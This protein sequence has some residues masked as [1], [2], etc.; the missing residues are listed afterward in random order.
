MTWKFQTLKST[1]ESLTFDD[2]DDLN[3]ENHLKLPTTFRGFVAPVRQRLQA[4]LGIPK[5][6]GKTIK[7]PESPG[8]GK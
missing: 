2:F 7:N 8:R 3:D 1:S 4:R 5:G 6:Q